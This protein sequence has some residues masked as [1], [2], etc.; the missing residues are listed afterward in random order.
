MD[1]HRFLSLLGLMAVGLHGVTLFLDETIKIPLIGFFVPGFVP[2]RPVWTSVGVLTAELMLIIH[3]S[4][5][6]RQK[7]GVRVWRR[8]HFST[9][10]AFAGATLHGLLAGTD[11]SRTWMLAS[12]AGVLGLVLALTGWRA[13]MEKAGARARAA[14]SPVARQSG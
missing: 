8:L 13:T 12:Y 3:L 7:M 9:Y 1:L 6:W 14:A 5:R 10:G 2:Y 11:S 4:F